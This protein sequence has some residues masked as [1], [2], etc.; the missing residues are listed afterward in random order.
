MEPDEFGRVPGVDYSDQSWMV[1]GLE[2]TKDYDEAQVLMEETDLP[3][4]NHD[5]GA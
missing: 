4:L 2:P 5:I 3:I 1:A